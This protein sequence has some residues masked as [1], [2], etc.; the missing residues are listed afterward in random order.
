MGRDIHYQYYT[1]KEEA[2][3]VAYS[4]DTDAMEDYFK[5]RNNYEI[6]GGVYDIDDIVDRINDLADLLRTDADSQKC[7]AIA[8]YAKFLAEMCDSSGKKYLLIVAD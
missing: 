3:K 8:A 5:G 2:T 6:H 1:T 7:K 4:E